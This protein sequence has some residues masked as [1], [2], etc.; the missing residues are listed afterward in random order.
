MLS[1][2]LFRNGL[3]VSITILLILPSVL[4][5][6]KAPGKLIFEDV[7]FPAAIDNGEKLAFFKMHFKE[8]SSYVIRMAIGDPKTGKTEFL[9]PDV[10]F[11]KKKVLAFAFTADYQKVAIVDRNL[12]PCDIW[13]YDR[14]EAY[15]EPIRL[16]DL[17]QFDPGFD[18]TSLQN[19]GLRPD[20]V[21]IVN[22]IDFSRDGNNLLMTFGILGKSA[23]WMYEMDRN[24]YRQLTKDRVGYL[25][26]WLPDSEHFVYARNDTVSG[27]FSE[28]IYLMNANNNE[29]EPLVATTYSESWP[30]PSPDGKYVAFLRSENGRW[31][32][33]VIRLSDRKTTRITDIPE[34][35]SCNYA[36]WNGD[37][38]KIYLL[39]S[40]FGDNRFT[41]VYELE[42]TPDKYE[43]K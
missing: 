12:T 37:A 4:S 33:Y 9:L 20:E 39:L 40:G 30:I 32:C 1:K 6:A 41:D 3:I 25:P 11:S 15:A 38:S 36:A 22:S 19:L 26:K 8:D 31:N 28:D 18:V 17:E 23:I 24:H 27:K 10:N 34:R 42:F 7:F 29:S 35:T 2:Q 16:T 5:A 14:N 43:W 13:L 21:L